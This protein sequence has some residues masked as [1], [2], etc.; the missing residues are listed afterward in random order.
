MQASTNQG[1]YSALGTPRLADPSLQCDETRP[2]CL[3]CTKSQRTCH[4]IRAG[5][6]HSV[7]HIENSYA[8]G[9]KQ[10]PRGPRPTPVVEL[11]SYQ[12]PLVNLKDQA[13]AYYFHHH[14]Q[15][16]DD[17]YSL[18]KSANHFVRTLWMSR[19]EC[20]ILDLAVSSMA[21]AVFSNTQQHLPAALEGSKRY[22]RLLRL[23][24]SSI[25]SLDRGNVDA[26]LLGVF[27]MGRYEDVSH[28]PPP[29]SLTAPFITTVRGFL[30]HDGSL[31]ILKYWKEN[32]SHSQ[33]ATDVIKHAR[34]GMI[35]SAILRNRAL[36]EWILDGASFGE[37]GLE[38]EY[39]CMILQ[40]VNARHQLT[41]I[42]KE[43]TGSQLISYELVSNAESLNKEA[44]K[45]DKA[46][47]GWAAR[48]P[49]MWS[50][51][52]HTL[53]D[54]H[55][56]P[57]RGFHSSM[58]YSYRSPAIASI[59]NQYYA[60]RMLI[61]STRLR[62]L[63]IC[64]P[65][66]SDLAHGEQLECLSSMK[67]MADALAASVALC[68]QRSKGAKNPNTPLD[69]NSITLNTEDSIKPYLADLT[70]WPLTIASCLGNMDSKQRW[71]FRSELAHVGKIAGSRMLQCAESHQW[72]EL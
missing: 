23:A 25:S 46:F 43:R 60:I 14:L 29:L 31:A 4:R 45:I 41:T 40:V 30:H 22:Q 38:L 1:K 59:C 57:Q 52:S 65:V 35:R 37:H 62:L 8:S 11:T 55:P 27:F 36:P 66:P 56:W 5:Q 70:I 15:T 72:L 33:P 48:F 9:Q 16:L 26:W 7:V 64:H 44:Q 69:P 68:L 12:P 39:D 21:L 63:G 71:W 49:D 42:M 20:P 17:A 67:N 34:R 32:L 58:V 18:S 3:R 53:T 10:R 6:A 2:I 24:Q 13:V 54:T 61:Y 28:R 19:T 51:Q 50:Y 47:R